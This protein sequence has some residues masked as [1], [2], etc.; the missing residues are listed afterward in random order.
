[1]AEEPRHEPRW[2][3]LSPFIPDI[4]FLENEVFRMD[5]E[6]IQLRKDLEELREDS[7]KCWIDKW[8]PC[9]IGEALHEHR[10]EETPEVVKREIYNLKDSLRRAGIRVEGVI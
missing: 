9:M 4:D 6:N 10:P 8:F 5:E 1:M 2:P 7:R 3:G